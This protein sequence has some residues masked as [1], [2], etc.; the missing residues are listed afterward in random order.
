M[1]K[2]IVLSFGILLCGCSHS[3]VIQE[4]EKSVGLANPASTFCVERG[5][6]LEIRDEEE[7]QVGYCHLSDGTVVEEWKFFREAN[8]PVDVQPE[9]PENCESWFDGCN[10]CRVGKGG[11]LA[12]TRKFCTPEM[13]QEPKCMKFKEEDGFKE[14]LP[15]CQNFPSSD[16]CAGGIKDIIIIDSSGDCPVYGCVS[17]E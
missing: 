1:K 8:E 5:G 15:M 6:E 11:M 9:I 16:F 10:N 14:V 2:I 12:C 13:M 7:G 17:H 3:S 4:T